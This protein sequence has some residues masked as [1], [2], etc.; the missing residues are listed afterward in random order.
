VRHAGEMDGAICMELKKN[1]ERGIYVTLSIRDF[2][3]NEGLK[4][5]IISDKKKFRKFVYL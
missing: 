4:L 2:D 1:L 5:I 3:Q